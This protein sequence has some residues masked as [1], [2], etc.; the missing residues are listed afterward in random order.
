MGSLTLPLRIKETK[1]ADCFRR[2]TQA[3]ARLA[4]ENAELKEQN[5]TLRTAAT[6]YVEAHKLMRVRFQDA[7][8]SA[9]YTNAAKKLEEV[10]DA[11]E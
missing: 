10:L 6:E 2:L 11:A 3:V 4:K 7:N 9:T 5:T 1:G 8:D